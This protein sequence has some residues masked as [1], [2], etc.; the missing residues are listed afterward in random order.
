MPQYRILYQG[1]EVQTIPNVLGRTTL[2]AFSI[3]ATESVA[4]VTSTADVI[5]GMPICGPGLPVGAFV[6]AVRSATELDLAVSTFNRS[7]GAW[8]T[9]AVSASAT[10]S[11]K[12]AEV[13]GHHPL[14]VVEQALP[15]GMWRNHV[16][17]INMQVPVVGEAASGN[18]VI[19]SGAG[20]VSGPAE[21]TALV[22]TRSGATS[23]LTPTFGIKDDSL[24][25]TPIKR[26]NGEIWGV[27][28]LVSTG[29]HVSFIPAHPD[30]QVIYAG[31]DEA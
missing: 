3:T 15:M 2:A 7:T 25:A 28:P 30:W 4:T 14:C 20:N 11:S 8:A 18:V 10:I 6:A 1:R 16:P 23:T 13:F 17:T 5:A 19:I 9:A 24:A 31:A 22:S 26:H 12:T 27:R 29:G 21:V